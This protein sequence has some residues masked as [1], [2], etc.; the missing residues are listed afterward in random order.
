MKIIL[1]ILGFILFSFWLT[2]II[3]VG[4]SAGMKMFY[5]TTFTKEENKDESI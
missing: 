2:I 3:E 1:F 5:K 4:V